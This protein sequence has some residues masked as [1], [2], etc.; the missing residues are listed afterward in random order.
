MKAETIKKIFNFL[1]NNEGKE[2]PQTV[3]DFIA[4]EKLIQELENHPDGVQYKHNGNL[5]LINSKI[6]KL[7][8][9]LY[10]T[11]SLNLENC[12]Q[13]TKLPDNL[14]V[15]DNLL[16]AEINIAKFSNDLYVGGN[17]QLVRLDITKLPN[18]LH[19]RGS[20]KLYGCEQLTELPDNLYV[21]DFFVLAGCKQITELPNN[22]YVGGALHLI[23]ISLTEK[24]TNEE[25]K[26]I[27]ASTGGQIIG[28]VFRY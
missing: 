9:D 7:P 2:I 24:Y 1:K 26:E 8:N 17:L 15:G 28:N 3:L 16:I 23:N 5:N 25:I 12:K 6:K 18:D 10:V 13:L 14:Y 22:L 20:F 27:V 11:G 4:K 19:I 21:E